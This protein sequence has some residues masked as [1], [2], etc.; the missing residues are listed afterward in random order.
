MTTPLGGTEYFLTFIDDFSSFF[1]FTFQSIGEAFQKFKGLKSLV[2]NCSNCKI[3]TA[4]VE[5]DISVM[6]FINFSHF[7]ELFGRSQTCCEM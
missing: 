2:E 6:S 5:M 7:M 3:K 4:I 1:I